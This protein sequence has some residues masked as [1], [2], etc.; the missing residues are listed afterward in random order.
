MNSARIFGAAVLTLISLS[1]PCRAA[2]AG[3]DAERLKLIP[4]RLQEAVDQ[5]HISGAVSLIAYGG[6]VAAL[7]AVGWS[8]REANKRM[9]ADTIFQI[10]SQTKT[11]T[12]VAAM[13]LVEEGRLDLTRPVSDYLPEFKDQPLAAPGHPPHH[14]PTVWQLMNHSAGFAFLPAAGPYQKLNYT[15]DATL[16]DAVRGFAREPLVSEPGTKYS[17]SNMGIATLGRI[18]EVI[19]GTSYEAFVANRILKPLGMNDTFF[20]P[21]QAKQS[22]IAMVYTHEDGKVVLAHEKAQGG[23]SAKFRA[24]AKYPGPE[25]G[26]FSTASDLLRF[27]GMLAAGGEWQG[28]RYLS[29]QSIEAMARD[30][31]PDGSAYGLTMRVEGPHGLFNLMSPGTFGHG[32]AFGTIGLIDPQKRL[33]VIFLAQM[34]DGTANAAKNAV[35]QIAESAVQ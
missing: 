22:R 25:L 23:D 10:M 17:Y 8:D 21:P 14:P 2:D 35:T 9:T 18:V 12:G 4:A 31:T 27:Y 33:I 29:R 15:L 11:V 20:F 19:S 1:L 34:I 16:A 6:K 7:D 3:I 30:Y 26:L 5:G 32:G 24:G 13:M 28:R